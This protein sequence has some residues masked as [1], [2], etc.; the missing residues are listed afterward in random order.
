MIQLKLNYID[1]EK[2]RLRIQNGKSD[3]DRFIPIGRCALQW[4]EKYLE[5][6]RPHYVKKPDAGFL[7]ITKGGRHMY[8]RT[9]ATRIRFYFKKA[10][11][12]KEGSCHIFRH[13]M[14]THLLA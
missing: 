3:K 7:F 9:F 10:G 11:I 1:W 6:V 13:T 8:E 5:E 2:E 12:K 14:A 4:V